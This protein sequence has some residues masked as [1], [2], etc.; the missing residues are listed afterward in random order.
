MNQEI[1]KLKIRLAEAKQKIK[2]ID[3]EAKG[4][5]LVIRN[6]VDPYETLNQL[7]TEEALASMERLHEL[8]QGRKKIEKQVGEYEEALDV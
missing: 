6:Y 7:K 8:L 2:D 5:I 4:L 3:L 1:M